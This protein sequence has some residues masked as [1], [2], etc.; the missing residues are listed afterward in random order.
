MSNYAGRNVTADEQPQLVFLVG[1]PRS[2]TTWLQSL[3]GNHPDIATAQESHLFNH[4]LG[5]LIDSW[6]H[7]EKFED[8]RGGIGL[9]AYFTTPAFRSLLRDFVH[10][11]FSQVPEYHERA[12]FLEKTPDHIRNLAQ[13]KTIIPEA[14]IIVLVRE[15]SDVIESMLNASKGWGRN[16]AP[17]SIVSAI[18]Q[19]SYFAKKGMQDLSMLDSSDYILVKYEALKKDPVAVVRDVLSYIGVSTDERTL[20]MM[21]ERKFELKKFGEFGEQSGNLV[22]EPEGFARK[23]KGKLSW[24]Q[25]LLVSLCLRQFN[26]EFGY[27]KSI[28]KQNGVK[29]GLSDTKSKAF[30][31]ENSKPASSMN[32]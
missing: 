8:G 7:M 3:L 19:F 14:R 23:K 1:P 17:Q 20:E 25:K 5:P 18:R 30:T 31:V 28:T 10:T 32:K 9:P 27:E 29:P 24:Y 21:T 22:K 16:W 13:I 26:R 15:P 6:H 4:F 11:T 12:Y 2:G